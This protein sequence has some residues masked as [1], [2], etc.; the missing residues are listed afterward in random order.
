MNS[1]CVKTDVRYGEQVRSYLSKYDLVDQD[2]E[3]DVED[4]SIYIPIDE[5]VEQNRIGAEDDIENN[6]DSVTF[7]ISHEPLEVGEVLTDPPY[8]SEVEVKLEIRSFEGRETGTKV[9]DILGFQP[10]YEVVGGTALVEYDDLEDAEKVGEA[11]VEADN[12]VDSVYNVDSKVQGRERTRKMTQVAGSE[13]RRLIHT[14]YGNSFEV[15]LGE[16]YFTPRLAN[17][18]QRVKG[19]V[20]EDE[21][22]LDMFAGVGPY[23]VPLAEVG[24]R[25]VAVDVNP[26]ATQLLKRNV[27]RN[28][29]SDAVDV[30]LG[31]VSKVLKPVSRVKESGFEE[32]GFDR[33]VMN[34]PHSADE[35]LDTAVEVADDGAVL[36]YYSFRHEDDLY[37]GAVEKI[38]E[39]AEKRGYGVEVLERVNVRSYAPYEYNICIDARLL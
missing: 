17:E 2:L 32:G 5:D 39:A 6:E 38:E 15:G 16:V 36:H 34:L 19:L 8:S 26:R 25:V 12:N 14:E 13:G 21:Q 30:V 9:E 1:L 11:L 35:F 31:D 7:S 29:V 22:L 10:G 37:G 4:G 24:S 33:M 3:I 27:D 18:R 28:G 23:T 20:E